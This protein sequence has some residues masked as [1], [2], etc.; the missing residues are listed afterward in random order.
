MRAFPAGIDLKSSLCKNLQYFVM[1]INVLIF[2]S[3]ILILWAGAEIFVKG[4]AS[5]SARTGIPALVVGLTVGALGTSMPEIAVSWMAAASGRTDIA[6]GNAIGSNMANIGLALGIGALVSPVHIERDV[7]KKD[8]WVML[9]SA[10]LLFVFSAGLYI[11]RA[12]GAVLVA[13][14]TAY[15]IFLGSRRADGVKINDARSS[16]S[17]VYVP[18][19]ILLLLA[20]GA[21]VISGA[22]ASARSL[23]I[24]QTVIALSAVALGTSLPEMA[25][26]IAGSI[27]KEHQISMGTIVGSN[28]YNI[29]FVAGGAAAIRGIA[30]KKEEAV[31]KAPAVL[32]MTLILLP[33]ILTG[34]RLVKAEGAVLFVLF[35]AY[36]ALAFLLI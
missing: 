28:I 1:M 25:V 23:G 19:G 5:L 29:F 2:V 8:Y 26:V 16:A 3:G 36:L 4:A 22:Q 15:L 17:P 11:N 27:R 35:S 30:L 18:F 13:C 32:A 33:L 21:L 14:G 20:G 12:S 31:F 24:S 10:L 6:I 34:R 7:I 9:F